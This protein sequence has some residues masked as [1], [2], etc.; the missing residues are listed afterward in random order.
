MNKP[1][2]ALVYHE[3]LSGEMFEDFEQS[4]SVE[5]INV[6]VE[7]REDEGPMMCPEWFGFAAIMAYISKP[8]FESAL[9][10]MGKDH[11]QLLK[12][13]LAS[14]T[15]EVMRKPKIEPVLVSTKGKKSSN[16][17][18][19]LAMFIYAQANDGNKV[20]L[21]LPKFSE[22]HDYSEIVN[23]FMEFMNEYY[24]G[25]KSMESIGFDSSTK[26][27][28]RTIFVHMNPDTKE[29]EWLDH[30]EYR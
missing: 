24:S 4:V 7:S 15:A 14:L 2:I 1:D 8:Y 30:H 26:P 27:P 13:K 11:Y 17:P 22:D 21:L 20:Q 9:K 29:I 6:V 19:S 3:S 25:I 16:N 28:S 10:E 18:Y 12:E 5:S 23:S